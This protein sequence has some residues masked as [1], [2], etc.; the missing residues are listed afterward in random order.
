LHREVVR[1]VVYLT[2]AQH[3]Q[4]LE[5]LARGDAGRRHLGPHQRMAQAVAFLEEKQDE[6]PYYY[7]DLF[8]KCLRLWEELLDYPYFRR[9]KAAEAPPNLPYRRK[10][11]QLM[12]LGRRLIKD[13]ADQHRQIR[14]ETGRGVP[15]PVPLT[16]NARRPAPGQT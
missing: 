8:D 5:R 14:E 7:P 12:L 16:G 11:W 13:L 9:L 4:T 6:L 1:R 10:V 15:L 2:Q 3:L